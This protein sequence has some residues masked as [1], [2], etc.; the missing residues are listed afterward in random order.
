MPFGQLVMLPTGTVVYLGD[1]WVRELA[2]NLQC[3]MA[4]EV[5]RD[6]K[7]LNDQR[8]LLVHEIDPSLPVMEWAQREYDTRVYAGIYSPDKPEGI[9]RAENI[10]RIRRIND[11]EP[12]ERNRDR[13]T[14]Y[15]EIRE[16][17]FERFGVR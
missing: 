11:I 4:I 6:A 5:V 10:A 7:F 1:C 12:D 8:Y 17:L 13:A 2:D 9:D 3:H 14:L 15:D 16:T